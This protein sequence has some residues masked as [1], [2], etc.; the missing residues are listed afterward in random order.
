MLLGGMY[1][2]VVVRGVY[3]GALYPP[4]LRLPPKPPPL[5]RAA[6]AT[7]VASARVVSIRARERFIPSEYGVAA[8]G[9]PPVAARM[10]A[11]VRPG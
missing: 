3:R 8:S 5:R 1:R 11:A 9:V 4:E 2:G 7:P 6:S 10:K